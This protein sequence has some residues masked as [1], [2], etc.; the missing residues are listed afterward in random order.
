[1]KNKKIFLLII[2]MVTAV[3]AYTQQYNAEKDFLTKIVDNGKGVEITT[4]IGRKSEV[5]IPEYIQNLP[6]TSIGDW[7]FVNLSLTSLTSITISNTVKSIE[8]MAFCECRDLTTI[9][10]DSGNRNY[11][12]EQGVLYNKNK[13]TLIA[14][15]PGK[16]GAFTI[17]N[18]K[19]IAE[20]T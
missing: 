12:S 4:Y 15:P 3:T 18:I 11:S 8:N 16:K 17:P 5:R 9:N 13:S 1:M 10:V 2:L 14:Y 6:V 19:D 20:N 7:A